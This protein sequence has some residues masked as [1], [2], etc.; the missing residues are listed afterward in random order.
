MVDL[1][2]HILPGLDDGASSME[3]SIRM[4]RQA[5]AGGVNYI[6]ASSHGNYYDYTVQEYV[7]K[8]RLLQKELNRQQIPVKIFPSMEI[9]M[10]ERAMQLIRDRELLFINHT[11]YLMIEFDFRESPERVCRM[12]A[13]LQQMK[14]NII[15]AHP[16]RYTFIQEDPE[17]AYYLAERGCV[18]QVNKG[19]VLGEFGKKVVHHM[20]MS[21]KDAHYVGGLVNGARIVVQWG[22]VGTELMVYADG[23]ISLFL[24]YEKI[25]FTAPVYVGDF[26]EYVGWIEE[27]GNQSYKCKFEAWKVATMLD[28]TDADMEGIEHTA[29][30][31]CEPPIL[32]ATGTGSL[33]IAKKDQRGPQEESFKDLKHRA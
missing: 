14:Y 31:A 11:R 23:D 15:L 26:M 13:D 28:R 19:S 30:T 16:E 6:A 5:A 21:E 25:E 32:C 12:V 22:D 8:F 27:V 24:G 4:A 2:M 3:E 17:L 29:A 20:M 18:L 10:N 7:R 1:H 9:F 33:Y